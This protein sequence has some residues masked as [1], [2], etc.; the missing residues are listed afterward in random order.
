MSL[1]LPTTILP[2]HDANQLYRQGL[3]SSLLNGD[4][5]RVAPCSRLAIK[6]FID[7]GRGVVDNNYKDEIGVVLCNHF[8][9][10]FFEI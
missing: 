8:T 10:D 1:A 7:V 5:V 2:L 6:S 9:K 4:Y 3:E